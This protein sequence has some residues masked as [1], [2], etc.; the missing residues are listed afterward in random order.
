MAMEKMY[1]GRWDSSM[2]GDYCWSLVRECNTSYKEGSNVYFCSSMEVSYIL[3][4][5]VAFS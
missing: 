1:Q 3:V 5:S 4:V 2:M